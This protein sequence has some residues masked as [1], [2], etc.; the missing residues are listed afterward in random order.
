M[1][2]NYSHDLDQIQR[3]LLWGLKQLDVWQGSE[4]PHLR[5]EAECQAKVTIEEIARNIN[6]E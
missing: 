5:H 4:D 1:S 2:G 6:N 3:Q